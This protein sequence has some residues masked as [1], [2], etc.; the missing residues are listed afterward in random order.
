MVACMTCFC[1]LLKYDF[2]EKDDHTV[3]SV[4]FYVIRVSRDILFLSSFYNFHPFFGEKM[5]A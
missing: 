4:F 5:S 2:R 1:F 3:C